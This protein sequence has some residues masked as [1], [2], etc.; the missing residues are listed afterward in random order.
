MITASSMYIFQKIK[1]LNLKLEVICPICICI[2]L[3]HIW[4]LHKILGRITPILYG[5]KKIHLKSKY[6]NRARLRRS[7]SRSQCRSSTSIKVNSS[8][9]FFVMSSAIFLEQGIQKF[10]T[11]Q[12]KIEARKSSEQTHWTSNRG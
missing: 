9:N 6:P 10:N 1:N 4:I 8:T 3:T 11:I 2:L 12:K 5:F 7:R